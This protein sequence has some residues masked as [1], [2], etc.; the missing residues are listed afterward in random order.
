ME[1]TAD[2]TQMYNVLGDNNIVQKIE[3]DKGYRGIRGRAGADLYRLIRNSPSKK[4]AF[5][6]ERH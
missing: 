2:N 6:Q 5:E 4:A 3:Q 1:E